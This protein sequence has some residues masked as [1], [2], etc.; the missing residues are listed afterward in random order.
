[1]CCVYVVLH[2]MYGEVKRCTILD[3]T[4]KKQHGVL[5]NFHVVLWLMLTVNFLQC[6]V[7]ETSHRDRQVYFLMGSRTGGLGST[8]PS[9]KI[10]W[11]HPLPIKC[12][13]HKKITYL[14]FGWQGNQYEN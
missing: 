4:K 3:P 13:P 10:F 11:G 2:W 1:M 12:L 9:L 6:L 5:L 14:P 8:G 7:F